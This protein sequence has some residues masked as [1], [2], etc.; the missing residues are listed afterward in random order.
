MPQLSSLVALHSLIT[1]IV[2]QTEDPT[3]LTAVWYPALTLG[4]I[5]NIYTGE[6][7]AI[8]IGQTSFNNIFATSEHHILRRECVDCTSPFHK[9]IFYKRITNPFTF[10]VYS[11]M[12]SWLSTDNILNTDFKLYTTLQDALTDSNQWTYCNYDDPPVGAFRDCGPFG[13]VP[14]N[15][16]SHGT[17]TIRSSRTGKFSILVNSS[18]DLDTTCALGSNYHIYGQPCIVSGDPHFTVWNGN[19]HDFQ[20]QPA[21]NFSGTFKEQYYYLHPCAGSSLTDDMPITIMGRHYHWGD[22]SV[23]GLDYITLELYDDNGDQYLAWFSSSIHHWVLNGFGTMNS[24][25]DAHDTATL[26]DLVSGATTNL[27]LEDKFKIT[28]A[29]TNDRRIDVY[30]EIGD[31]CSLQFYMYGQMNF[32][33][34]RYRMHYLQITPPFCYKC[35]SCGLCGDFKSESTGETIEFLETCDGYSIGYRAGWSATIEEAYDCNALSWEKSVV[36]NCTND[37]T[38]TPP[39]PGSTPAPVVPYTPFIGDD[40]A[41][42]PP[43][44]PSIEAQVI[45]ACQSAVDADA[46]CCAT[47]GGLF[48]D[49]LQ[50]SCEVDACAASGT[51]ASLIAGNVQEILSEPIALVCTIPDVGDQFDEE[52]VLALVTYA[53][54]PPSLSPTQSPTT[55]APTLLVG[56]ETCEDAGHIVHFDW[57]W[58]MSDETIAPD[59]SYVLNVDTDSL[60]LVIDV[61][62]DYVGSAYADDHTY[63]YGVTYI[64][65]FEDYDAEVDDIR[66]P[67]TCQNR[68]AADFASETWDQLWLYSDTPWVDNHIDNESYLAYPPSGEYWDLSID[69]TGDVCGPMHYHGEFEWGELL[70]C[71]N[72]DGSLNYI[73]L[74]ENEEWL[75]LT[76]V[77]YVNVF[78]PLMKDF[79]SGYYRAYQLLSAPFVIAVRK[80]V[81]VISSVGI[82]IFMA[83]IIAVYKEDLETDFRLII[84]TESADLLMLQSPQLL[85][86]SPASVPSVSILSSSVNS[87]CL[88]GSNTLCLQLWEIYA[89]NVTCPP[90]NFSGTYNLGFAATCNPSAPYTDPNALCVEYLTT[91][92]SSVALSA[93][94]EWL[95]EVCDPEVFIVQFES[96]MIFYTSQTFESVV[97]D[98]EQYTKGDIA[99]VEL[100]IDIPSNSFDIFYLQIMNVWLCTTAPQYEP[101]TV[102][103]QTVGSD[104]CL[105][106]NMDPD[107]PWH[108]IING[109]ASDLTPVGDEIV[110]YNA[111]NGTARFSFLVP[112]AVERTSLYVH[113]QASLEL[114]D[115]PA[116]RRLLQEEDAAVNTATQIRHFD[117]AIGIGERETDD[118]VLRPQGLPIDDV[119]I[120]T[121]NDDN[122][123]WIISVAGACV[124]M[125]C[126]ALFVIRKRCKWVKPRKESVLV[127][128]DPRFTIEDIDCESGSLLDSM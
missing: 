84:L 96:E 31:F 12:I 45:T 112:S 86:V 13:Y 79:D 43:C 59:M 117:G 68:V 102:S 80:T 67:G 34:G 49:E 38:P 11:S 104:G 101:L 110:I 23:T 89:N 97:G 37:E 7:V 8:D 121:E 116:R 57:D 128:D 22:R 44:D 26:N 118:D 21:R 93:D 28:Y 91:Y 99:Y 4:W 111:T 127:A 65:D 53:P 58:M 27:G 48:C 92:G 35:H 123:V 85:S 16:V 30:I 83:T 106:A 10:D 64:L 78:S 40:F 60:S 46:V 87:G 103:D 95:D 19:R 76:G 98:D 55:P 109:V 25:F 52:T 56:N 122:T 70:S 33:D 107:H 2:S 81:N 1:A 115:T 69:G 94:L 32:V 125:I 62:L 90:T 24:L 108:I 3:G 47:I 51:D 17:S 82:N 73:Q 54:T 113:V 120:G 119:S 20:G 39:A 66:E 6:T 75:N 114:Y 15:W 41:Y 72:Y 36:D 74:H 9:E 18:Y 5:D 29:Q 126:G 14:S 71:T 63:G 50:E 124:L 77:F 61:Y 105:S 100:Q 88:A 42:V